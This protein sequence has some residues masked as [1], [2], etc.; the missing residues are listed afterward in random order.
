MGFE[1]VSNPEHY[2]LGRTTRKMFV[3]Y[4]KFKIGN[5][6]VTVMIIDEWPQAWEFDGVNKWPGWSCFPRFQPIKE[7][8]TYV[9]FSLVDW[10]LAQPQRKHACILNMNMYCR[11]WH[12]VTGAD[13]GALKSCKSCL[14]Q[15]PDRTRTPDHTMTSSNGNIFRVTGHRWIPLTK[16]SDAE[17]WC[18]WICA[19]TNS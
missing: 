4:A 7:Y 2:Y 12:S 18:S 9:T 17:F 13:C 19:W 16:A 10:D 8:F 3:G 15:D 5:D 6:I 14:T 1:Y 11:A